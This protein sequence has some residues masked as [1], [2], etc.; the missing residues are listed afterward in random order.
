MAPHRVVLHYCRMKNRKS[1]RL[2]Q[3]NYSL[4]YYYYITIC[5]KDRKC[6]LGKIE[7]GSIYLTKTGQMVHQSLEN[8]AQKFPGTRIDVSVV[9]PNHIHF[10]LDKTD[11]TVNLFDIM[12]WFKSTTSNEIGKS[13]WQRN[14]Y[15]HIIRSE[16]ALN[17]IRK[18]I[19][20]NPLKW[21]LDHD[22]PDYKEQKK[23][24][25][26]AS[27]NEHCPYN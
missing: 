9:M 10:I 14:Y 6:L 15:E 20:N 23:P 4:G 8:I 17:S 13:L 18:Y 26:R 27:S 7:E 22:N 3:F 12:H 16:R 5:T 21:H 24:K 2:Q 19:E 1:L 25:K 11:S